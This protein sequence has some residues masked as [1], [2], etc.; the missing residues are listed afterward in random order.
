MQSWTA[1]DLNRIVLDCGRSAEF[2]RVVSYH[3]SI[4]IKF[5]LELDVL[6]ISGS[7]VHLE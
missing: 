4:A 1:L 6:N 7:S 5:D 2:T 3:P